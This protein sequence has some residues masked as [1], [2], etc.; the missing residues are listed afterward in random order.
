LGIVAISSGG[1]EVDDVRHDRQ[2]DQ[3]G[4]G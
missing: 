1:A 3:D 4:G 2:R